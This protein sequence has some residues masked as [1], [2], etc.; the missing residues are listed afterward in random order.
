MK[1]WMSAGALA[2]ML[3]APLAS[4]AQVWGNQDRYGRGGRNLAYDEG[5][6]RGVQE[7]MTEGRKDGRSGD[8]F[9]FRDEGDY[10]NGDVGYRSSYGPKRQ[11][12]NGFRA[13]FEQG[14]G[15]AYQAESRYGRSNDRYGRDGYG[16]YSRDTRGRDGVYS[17][18]GGYD[19]GAVRRD[20]RV[21]AGVYQDR[22]G[23]WRYPDGRVYRADDVQYEQPRRW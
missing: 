17:R 5:F 23:V 19:S 7:G 3:A 13:G 1:A 18:D 14:Y 10:R 6:N 8:R 2:L 11:Y 12:V 4:D 22:Y 9:E 16:G 21:P 20:G 15:R